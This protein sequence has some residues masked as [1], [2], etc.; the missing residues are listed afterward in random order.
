MVL[1]PGEITAG[2]AASQYNNR[3]KS[4]LQWKGITK[5]RKDYFQPKIL[6]SVVFTEVVKPKSE[7][8]LARRAGGNIIWSSKKTCLK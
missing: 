5:K 4:L 3:N 2:M 7:G 6:N 8:N 1:L